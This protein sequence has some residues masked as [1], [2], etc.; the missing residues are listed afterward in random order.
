MIVK[1]SQSTTRPPEWDADSSPAVV[2]HN[3]DVVEVPTGEDTPAMYDY[4]QEVYTRQEYA[5]YLA[6]MSEAHAAEL[7][8]QLTETQLALCDSYEAQILAADAL[9]KSQQEITDTQLALCDVYELLESTL[10]GV[11]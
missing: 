11:I 6:R 8:E 9:E 3:F 5:E 10:G 7:E 2:Y 1:K 4:T